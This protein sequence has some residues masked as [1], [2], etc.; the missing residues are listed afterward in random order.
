MS[1]KTRLLAAGATLITVGGVGAAA[2]L[3]ATAATPACGSQCGSVFSRELGSYGQPNVVEDVLDGVAKVGQPV[4]LKHASG[5]DPSEDLIPHRG[6]VSDFYAAGMV[7]SAVNDHYG[8]LLAVQQEYAPFGIGTGLCVGLARVA[9]QNEGLTLQPCTVPGVT[10]FI[11]DT[12]DSPTTKADHYFPIV[13]GSTTIFRRPFAMVV[14][15]DEVASHQQTLQI[16]LR[17]LQ[18][19]TDE[20]TLPDRQ[21]WGFLTGVLN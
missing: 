9:Y 21:L 1:I 3:P 19:L 4:I 20:K 10:V 13:N 6:L 12:P 15:Q 11:I 7:S 17:H 14:P 5:S 16:R 18:F 2:T 8:T